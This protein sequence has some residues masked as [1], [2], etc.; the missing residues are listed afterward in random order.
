MVEKRLLF[1]FYPM[2]GFGPPIGAWDVCTSV[3]DAILKVA[4]WVVVMR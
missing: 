4:V 3:C 1:T 2:G